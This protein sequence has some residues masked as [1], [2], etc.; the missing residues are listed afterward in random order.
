[1]WQLA[2]QVV[3]VEAHARHVQDSLSTTHNVSLDASSQVKQIVNR[4]D[5]MGARSHQFDGELKERKAEL[6]ALTKVCSRL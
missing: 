5:K 3:G 1:M 4:L 2:A 6:T